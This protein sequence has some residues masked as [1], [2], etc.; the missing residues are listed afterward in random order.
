MSHAPRKKPNRREI[1]LVAAATVVAMQLLAATSG[2]TQS[3]TS[4]VSPVEFPFLIYC[5]YED[6]HRA[7]YFS[8]VGPDGHAIYISPD[9]QAGTI[10]LDGIAERI[11]GDRPGSCSGKTIEDLRRSGQAFDARP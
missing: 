10:T 4:A 7:Y 9:R 8:R 2:H 6:I 5:E 11:G 3:G 1:P